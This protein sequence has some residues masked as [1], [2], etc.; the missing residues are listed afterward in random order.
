MTVFNH[1]L[2]VGGRFAE[3][4][5]VVCNRIARWDG[6]VWRNLGTGL[7]GGLFGDCRVSSLAVHGGELVVGGNFT[8]AGGLP[9]NFIAT[10]DGASWHALGTGVEPWP[11]DSGHRIVTIPVRAV[12][13]YDGEVI[14]AASFAAAGGVPCNNIARWNGTDWQPL[15]DGISG[16]YSW[17][18]V[19]TVNQGELIAGGEFSRRTGAQFDYIARWNGNTWQP[20]DGELNQAVSALLSFP[21]KLVVGGAFTTAG[22]IPCHHIA[23]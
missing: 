22:G 4:D 1:E 9:C 19:L 3:V 14:V 8:Y 16:Q 21:G 18:S 20:F 7:S 13:V 6:D 15:G 2:I 11:L 5:D 23:V 10:W 17:V 12:A